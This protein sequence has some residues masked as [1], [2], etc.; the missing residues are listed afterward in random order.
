[1]RK[2]LDAGVPVQSLMSEL[3][4]GALRQRLQSDP[5]KKWDAAKQV[6]LWCQERG[7]TVLHPWHELYPR[8]LLESDRPPVF[9]SVWGGT[10]WTT[11]TGLAIVGSREP[12]SGALEWMEAYL[13]EVLRVAGVYS[14]SGGARGI[15]QRAHALSLRSG[16]PT[17]AFLPSGLGNV[18]PA[19]FSDWIT[20][21]RE[22]GGAIV[23][24][25]PPRARMEKGNFERR[26]R[27][28]A[29]LGCG[30][31]VVEA[32]RRSGSIM[33]ARLALEAGRSVCALPSGPLDSRAA[34]TM[35]LLHDGATLIRDGPDLVGFIALNSMRGAE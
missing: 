13:P 7:A 4:P 19:A 30:L 11:R 32:A 35:D 26:N 16:T 9:L 5:E 14:I 33:T 8:R 29:A 3:P 10:P 27:M 28:I 18:Y 23:S 31:F 12:T 22:G 21:I 20:G 15:D 24:E 6:L 25:F 2:A 1:M 34:G 17:V